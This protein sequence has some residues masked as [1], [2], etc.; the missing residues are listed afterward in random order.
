[1]S[2]F[3]MPEPEVSREKKEQPKFPVMIPVAED[4]ASRAPWHHRLVVE[5]NGEGSLQLQRAGG[6]WEEWVSKSK[7]AETLKVLEHERVRV[8][9][10]IIEVQKE[11]SVLQDKLN[12]QEKKLELISF[13]MQPQADQKKEN[14]E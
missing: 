11:I 7:K 1:M 14:G 5:E 4:T 9:D 3:E 2:K 8:M 10:Q 6:P 13:A 12:Y